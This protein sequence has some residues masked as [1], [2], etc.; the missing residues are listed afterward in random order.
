MTYLFLDLSNF[1]FQRYHGIQAWMKHSGT[2]FQ[3]DPNGKMDMF[4]RLFKEHLVKLKKKFKVDWGNFYIARDCSR[5]SI[6]RMAH[7]PQYKACRTC[8]NFDPEAFRVTYQ[9]LLPEL[10]ETYKGL[11][12]LEY[13]R[14]EAD[15]LIAVA[16]EMLKEYGVRNKV[17]V[18]T[19][20]NDYIQLLGKGYQGE[21]HIINGNLKD[22]TERAKTDSI[23]MYL[24]QKIIRGDV[25]D[26]IPP[27]KA[28]VGEKTALKY[29]E[30]PA[31][32]H[33]LLDEHPDVKKQYELNRLLIDFNSIPKNIRDGIKNAYN[34]KMMPQ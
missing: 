21:I 25:S 33:K 18:I 7:Y 17:V 2:D 14:A 10:L 9:E 8:T 34:D 12:V 28:K 11:T 1:V 30:D 23:S 15:D 3:N 19:N 16:V 27:I 29:A 31:A 6:W 4:K 26:N 20:D 24:E 13:P 32:L 22:I 5:E